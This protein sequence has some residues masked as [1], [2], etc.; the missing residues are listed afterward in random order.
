MPVNSFSAA[1]L[2]PTINFILFI[3]FY[4]SAVSLTPL[5]NI[6]SRSSPRIF[7]KKVK[8]F[9]MGY[10]EAWGTLIHEKTEVENLVSDPF[11]LKFRST[12]AHGCFFQL[13]NMRDFPNVSLCFYCV[14]VASDGQWIRGSKFLTNDIQPIWVI[15]TRDCRE[16]DP[17][18]T[19]ALSLFHARW[20]DN[21]I[22]R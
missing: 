7:E 13:V 18:F 20:I 2:T 21:R 1:S 14:C 11:K 16:R 22:C 4:L 12:F 9:L 3:N 6:H 15:C 5:I 10:S 8:T 19:W 17:R